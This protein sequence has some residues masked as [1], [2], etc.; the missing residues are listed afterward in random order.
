MA[1]VK[2]IYGFAMQFVTFVGIAASVADTK[3]I[4]IKDFII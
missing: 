1:A 3:R 2:T 4:A